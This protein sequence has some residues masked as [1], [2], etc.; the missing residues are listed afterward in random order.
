MELDRVGAE[1]GAEHVGEPRQPAGGA[2]Q[3]GRPGDRR[4]IV[5]RQGERH[6][7]PAHRQPPHHLAHRLGLGAVALEELQPRRRGV[8]QVPDLDPGATAER[9][10]LDL[11]LVA[12]IDN[13]RPGVG[14]GGV[15]GRD[16]EPRDRADRGQRLTAKAERTDL[17]QIVAVELGGGMAIDRQR[18]VGARHAAAIVGD[19]NEPPAAALGR[20]LDPGGAG[21]ERVL[22]QL[23]D[24]AG[25]PLD[26]LAGGDAVDQGFGKL[27]DRHLRQLALWASRTL[28]PSRRQGQRCGRISL[29][30]TGLV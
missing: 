6:V 30:F 19:A 25:R 2:G 5:A 15:A 13:D 28:T 7:G 14:L 22:D 1:F 8:E 12:G 3:C 4:A 24:R 20:D 23:L 11:G 27:A 10:G 17:Q 21:V 18:Q 16:A 29:T 26:H 9:R